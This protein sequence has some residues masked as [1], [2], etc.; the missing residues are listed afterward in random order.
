MSVLILKRILTTPRI[1]NL[2]LFYKK[3][4]NYSS[5]CEAHSHCYPYLKGSNCKPCRPVQFCYFN[6]DMFKLIRDQFDDT[7]SNF[8]SMSMLPIQLLLNRLTQGVTSFENLVTGTLGRQMDFGFGFLVTE[9]RE[10]SFFGRYPATSGYY[11]IF[12]KMTFGDLWWSLEAFY[13]NFRI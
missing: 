12:E 8:R 4:K 10:L 7:F 3:F 9:N 2:S 11:V 5:H 13:V 1:F 6:K